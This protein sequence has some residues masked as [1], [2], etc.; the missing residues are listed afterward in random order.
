MRGFAYWERVAILEES[1]MSSEEAI[2]F[3]NTI[4]QDRC[5]HCGAPAPRPVG[6]EEGREVDAVP[7]DAMPGLPASDDVQ[8]MP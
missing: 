2:A 5:D 3:A 6:G 7:G 1:G 4:Y 8:E